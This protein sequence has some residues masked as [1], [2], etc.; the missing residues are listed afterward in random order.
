MNQSNTLAGAGFMVLSTLGFSVM[1]AMIQYL[2]TTGMHGF[3]IAF[4]RNVFGFF[5]LLPIL[6]RHG[7]A[8]FRTTRLPLHGLRAVINSVAMLLFFYGITTGIALGL[9]QALSFTAPLFVSVLAVL[10][11]GER[12]RAHRTAALVI[13]FVG[14]LIILRPGVAHIPSG[15]IYILCSAMVW[16]VAMII[17]KRLTA[18]DSAVTVALYMVLMMGP[19]SGIAAAFVWT[20]PTP[21]QWPW[22]V[23]IGIVGTIAQLSFTQAFRLADATAVL[24]FDFGKLIFSALLG[25]FLFAQVLDLWVWVGGALIFFGGFYIAW[26]ERKVKGAVETTQPDPARPA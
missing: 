25:Y 1:H 4:F 9:V 26:R 14:A 16:G 10:F 2:G 6:M 5:A 7:L 3:E 15:A 11:L 24:P 23:A 12:F 19:I 20:W 21:E 17:I 18:T 22:L 8:P 13:G